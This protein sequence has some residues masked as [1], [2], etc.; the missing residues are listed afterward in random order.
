MHRPEDIANINMKINLPK[1]K[2]E[3]KERKLKSL[4]I[5]SERYFLILC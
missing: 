5:M 2:T 3:L 4:N 1:E